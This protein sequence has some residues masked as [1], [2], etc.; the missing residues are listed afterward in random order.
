M[1]DRIVRRIERISL[2]N[3]GD[4]RSVGEGVQELRIPV[5]PGIRVYFG[6]QSD[7]IVVLLCGGD[8]HSQRSDIRRAQL[9][10]KDYRSRNDV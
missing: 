5:G 6:R 8:K 3:F 4:F 9:Y 10:W 2:G 1:A 7:A